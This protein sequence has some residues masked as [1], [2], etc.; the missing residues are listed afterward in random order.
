MICDP[1]VCLSLRVML[2]IWFDK[3]V[4]GKK[5]KKKPVFRAAQMDDGRVICIFWFDNLLCGFMVSRQ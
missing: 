1:T 2:N 5:R 4:E 3:V